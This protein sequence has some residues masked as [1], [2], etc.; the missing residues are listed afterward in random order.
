MLTA[1]RTMSRLNMEDDVDR[2]ITAI[3]RDL[4]QPM[5]F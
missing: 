3:R 4:I 1:L 5:D 2:I